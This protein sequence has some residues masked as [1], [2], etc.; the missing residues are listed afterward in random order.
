M[1]L[2]QRIRRQDQRSSAS[3]PETTKHGVVGSDPLYR[4][5]VSLV[6]Q[7]RK[8]ASRSRRVS[9][10]NPIQIL[11]GRAARAYAAVFMLEKSMGAD[12]TTCFWESPGSPLGDRCFCIASPTKS[13]KT[14]TITSEWFIRGEN[15]HFIC[16]PVNHHFVKTFSLIFEGANPWHLNNN[17]MKTLDPIEF[18]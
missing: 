9:I 7:C 2:R 15:H 6:V 3:C 1:V 10:G 18:I 17:M 14:F 13:K 11:S 12:D 8:H 5:G 16:R 4:K